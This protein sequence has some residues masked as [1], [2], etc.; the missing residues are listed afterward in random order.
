MME[1]KKLEGLHKENSLNTSK[2]GESTMSSDEKEQKR[3]TRR[4]FVKGAAVGAAGLAAAGVLASCVQEATPCPTAEPCP[5][6]PTAEPC[7]PC[8]T[9]EAAAPGKYAFE[10]PPAPIPASDIK[11]TI[12]TD[13]VVVGAGTAGMTAA[14]SAAE[15]GANVIAIEKG[16]TYIAHGGW[17]AAVNSRLQKEMGLEIDRD[18]IIAHIMTMG[19]YRADQRLVTLWADKSAEIMNW[20]LDMAEAAGIEVVLD[21]T[22]KPWY[23]DNYPSPH[24]FLPGLQ[25]TLLSML[26]SNALEK[27]VDIRYE[28]PAAR[29]L[30]EG[31]GR[32]TGV[33]AQ[34]AE[35]DYVQFNANKAVVLC[36]GGY[37]NNREMLE[38]YCDWRAL[39][40]LGSAYQPPLETG[41][42]HK[43]GLWIGAAMDDLPH[44]PM[45]FDS[46]V[47]GG[48]IGI[49]RQ[50]W[51]YVNL[52]GERF[53]NEDL[54]WD[55]ECNQVLRQPGHTRW[56]VWDDKYEQEWP[57]MKSQ[58]CKNLGPPLNM[59]DPNQVPDEV[60]K[61]NI[62][63][64][65]TIEELG[66][67]ME[68][69]VETFKA[70]VERYTELAR[71][72]KDVD[73]GKHPDRLTTLEKP[74]FYA[75][76]M[77]VVMLVTLNGFKIN[78]KMQVLDTERNVIPGLYAAG[79]VSGGFFE[80]EYPT[81]IPGCSHSR[82]WTFGYLAGKNAAAE[83]V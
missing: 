53:M 43:M 75:M 48:F 22:V 20:L 64:V 70:T 41:D 38:A 58:C 56:V 45:H 50:P 24:F 69:P 21:P 62:L 49:A 13:V 51:L 33:I 66:Q 23:F 17:N 37:S 77:G 26:E 7:P 32:V 46:P 57:K 25:A 1:D 5:T 27:G 16:S 54:P 19:A 59:Y 34:T 10:V 71:N 15:A 6:C 81:T 4:E 40:C 83:K 47:S 42:G 72:G 78:T 9:P 36:T 52:N 3:I 31:K 55:Y 39:E 74:P 30:R 18:E 61:G 44:C 63:K 80:I 73:Y 68:V 82:A 79:N 11:E 2:K 14:L 35:G 29:L 60:E 65:D 12:T 67:K 76:H 8:P 28:T